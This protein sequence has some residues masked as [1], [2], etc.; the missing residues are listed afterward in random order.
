MLIKK[1]KPEF[2]SLEKIKNFIESKN[3][4][5]KTKIA[6]DQWVS[7]EE[8]ANMIK[9]KPQCLV[10]KKSAIAGA[11]IIF[12]DSTTIHIIPIAP[13][14]YFNMFRKGI[15][16]IIFNLLASKKQKKATNEVG[17]IIKETLI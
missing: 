2:G 14:S 16:G 11:K 7:E 12:T 5:L 13:S 8:W 15:S 1:I 9:N 17:E 10:I 3:T 4:G 6:L